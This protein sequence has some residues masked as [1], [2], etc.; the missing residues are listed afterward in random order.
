MCNFFRLVW[1]CVDCFVNTIVFACLS[2]EKSI[3]IASGSTI[4]ERFTLSNFCIVV[5]SDKVWMTNDISISVIDWQCTNLF[6]IQRKIQVVFYQ[7]GQS[8]NEFLLGKKLHCSHTA[9]Q[10]F[11][12]NTHGQQKCKETIK[13]LHSETVIDVKMYR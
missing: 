5:I 9:S 8:L 7:S 11:R 12:R 4:E 10:F 1:Y 2:C 6:C 13:C 3:L